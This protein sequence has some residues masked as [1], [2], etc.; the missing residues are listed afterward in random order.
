LW[1]KCFAQG[2]EDLEDHEHTGWPRRTRT[3]LNIQD[4]ATL[5]C[6]NYSQ[7]V[8]EVAA[9]ISHGTFQKIPERILCY[10]AQH[11]MRP[12]SRLTWASEVHNQ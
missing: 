7:R 10:P 4:V 2:R 11:S 1:H 3:E 9:G 8:D 12:D 6:V 5:V